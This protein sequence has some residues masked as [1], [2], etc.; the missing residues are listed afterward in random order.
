[1]NELLCHFLIGIPGSGKSTFARQLIELDDRYCHLSP[2]TIRDQLYGDP[3]IQGE[4]SIIERQI[5]QMFKA[6]I[7]DGSPVIYDATNIQRQWRLDFLRHHTLPNV[8]WLGWVFHTPVKDCIQRNQMRSRTVPIDVIIDDAQSLNQHPPQASEGF[9][10]VLEV[11]LQEDGAVDL[12]QAKDL[13]EKYQN[14]L[15]G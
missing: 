1:M 3:I 9:L 4:W 13:I 5:H 2:D 7:G 11:P 12:N 8:H 6:A 10:A 14:Q 15:A